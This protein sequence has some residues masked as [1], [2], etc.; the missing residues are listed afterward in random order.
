MEKSEQIN[1][2]AAAL[3]KA[4][5]AIKGALKDT[6]NPFF[7]SKY[8]DLSSVWEAC[9]SQLSA[10]GLSVVQ[11][12]CQ[13]EGGINVETMLMHCSGQWISS[14]FTMPVAKQD[15]QAVGS[16]ITYA[17][18]YALAAMIGI[19]PEDDDDDGNAAT[20]NGDKIDRKT[21]EIKPSRITPSTGAFDSLGAKDKKEAELLA[22]EIV[23]FW[24][25]GRQDEAHDAFYENDL[26]TDFKVAVWELLKPHSAIR[27]GI[28][29]INESRKEAA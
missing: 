25:E 24:K 16:A 2:L 9:R 28:K 11:T 3:A 4:Q 7:K 27:N 22:S 8:A 20:G 17:R 26:G 23:G 12:P 10:N 1:E 5:G 18:R 15:A 21:G 19:A 14:Q 6:A 29:K 13:G